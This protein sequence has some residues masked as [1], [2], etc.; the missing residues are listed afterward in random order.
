MWR[1]ESKKEADCFMYFSCIN[2]H[3][4]EK[5]LN[6]TC[7]KIIMKTKKNWGNENRQLNVY[8]IVELYNNKKNENGKE[9][10][11]IECY[12]IEM[13]YIIHTLHT[14]TLCHIPSH[15]IKFNSW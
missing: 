5:I 1:I 12:A 3:I 15:K 10:E 9:I 7:I 6:K 2:I 14:Y 11:E 8:G 4:P 13:F